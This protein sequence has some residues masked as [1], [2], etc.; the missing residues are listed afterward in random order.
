MVTEVT[1]SQGGNGTLITIKGT[2]FSGTNSDNKVSFGEHSCQVHSS[3]VEE[4]ICRFD[5]SS[6]PAV[7]VAYA[8]SVNVNGRGNALA[9]AAEN[10]TVTH[11]LRP[12]VSS[13]SPNSGSTGGGTTLTV[14]GSGFS[15]N[16]SDNAIS[17]DGVSC[18]VTAASYTEVT[19]DLDVPSVVPSGA[20]EVV[21]QT[22]GVNGECVSIDKTKC[23][24][25]FAG[26]QTPTVQDFQPLTVT[27]PGQEFVL[28][29]SLLAGNAE[30]RI[31]GEVC[32]VTESSASQIK[33]TV[34]GL[35]AGQHRVIVKIHGKGNAVF[36]DPSDQTVTSRER[37][38]RLSPEESS[39]E[40]GL[41]LS[42]TG[43]GFDP[44]EGQTVVTIGGA[45]CRLESISHGQ[46]ECV[47]P[48]NSAGSQPVK[49]SANDIKFPEQSLTYSDA[50][51]PVVAGVS[52]VRGKG[53]DTIAISGS[54]LDASSGQVVV[55]IGEAAC[56]VNSAS[57]S[58]ISCTLPARASGRY[59]VNVEVPGKG[60][61]ESTTKFTFELK[62][63]GVS[64]G[65]SGYGGGRMIT[66][67]GHGFSHLS[68]V[69]V[70]GKV[71]P[72]DTESSITSEELS[73]E[74]PSSDQYTSGISNDQTCDVAITLRNEQSDTLAGAFKYVASKTSAISSVSP[75]RGGTGGGVLLTITG[76]GFGA[77]ANDNVVTIDGTPC[78]I[79]TATPTQITCETGAHNRTIRTKVRVEVGDQGKAVDSDADFYYVDVWSSRFSWGNNDPP[80]EGRPYFIA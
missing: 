78:V 63:D 39:K 75:S 46:I 31:G 7:A 2:G 8:V 16:P 10:A 56:S 62:L 29:G 41:L 73:C 24:F 48:P 69:T 71:C 60:K 74:V 43:N 5:R 49:I 15:S 76:T 80:K 40:G 37:V 57:S 68:L 52:P 35:V 23:D 44:A 53:G 54:N 45:A 55:T 38:I 47:T 20:H 28:S 77:T 22:K 14:S 32:N 34:K 25:E 50:A 13:V 18:L 12:S 72:I 3:N 67:Q 27:N 17:V 36:D 1:P 21:V 66:L 11:E 33:C 42:I 61:A 79:K 51:T 65:E 6:E 58:S 4:I 9:V 26:S 30:V 19:C 59:T 64:P 70:C